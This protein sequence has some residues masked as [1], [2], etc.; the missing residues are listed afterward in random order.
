[1]TQTLAVAT[2]RRTRFVRQTGNGHFA[3]IVVAFEPAPLQTWGEFSPEGFPR[4]FSAGA[5]EG[6]KR[7]LNG[8]PCQVLFLDGGY[9]PTDSR[10]GDFEYAGLTL[11]QEILQLPQGP[12]PDSVSGFKAVRQRWLDRW[13]E[14]RAEVPD[15]LER[16]LKPMGFESEG[17]AF[18]RQVGSLRQ[19]ICLRGDAPSLPASVDIVMNLRL[20]GSD[21]HLGSLKLSRLYPQGTGWRLEDEDLVARLL[22]DLDLGWLEDTASPEFL[23]EHR[24]PGIFWWS[25][26]VEG[27]LLAQ[28]GRSSEAQSLVQ[29]ALEGLR[30]KLGRARE[31]QELEAMLEGLQ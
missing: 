18:V 1:M 20:A 6:L 23:L 8:F 31:V 17:V 11:A 10:V 12:P 25:P 15:V 30:G 29:K 28:A 9:H 16:A 5:L 13:Q 2:L 4:E 27:Q 14:V 19:R 21:R 24:P 7:G 3:L 22:R 26:A